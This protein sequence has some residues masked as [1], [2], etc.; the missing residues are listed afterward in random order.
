MSGLKRNSSTRPRSLSTALCG[1]GYSR[2]AAC[3]RTESWRRTLRNIACRRLLATP[4]NDRMAYHP[5]HPFSDF[6]GPSGTRCHDTRT[7][8]F[9]T[10]FNGLLKN[11]GSSFHHGKTEENEHFEQFA[12]PSIFVY[13]SP[14]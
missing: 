3:R 4:P 9:S 10:V 12:N 14:A 2:M 5:Y 6:L 7:T 11:S 8:R 1:T 13:E